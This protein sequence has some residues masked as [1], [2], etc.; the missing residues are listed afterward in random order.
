[1]EERIQKM[2]EFY[3]TGLVKSI[4]DI[5]NGMD[6][7]S[8]IEQTLPE[9]ETKK[10]ALEQIQD[11]NSVNM[12]SASTVWSHI[13]N[14]LLSAILVATVSSLAILLKVHSCPEPFNEFFPI[15]G[16]CYHIHDGIRTWE[17]AND[18]CEDKN[19]MLLEIYT[20]SEL[21]Y[22]ER[23]LNSTFLKE[24]SGMWLGAS[25][26]HTKNTFR[27]DSTRKEMTFEGSWADGFPVRTSSAH[28]CLSMLLYKEFK[29]KWVNVECE[30]K[31]RFICKMSMR[32]PTNNGSSD[33]EKSQPP[34]P[35][36]F[37][38]L[39]SWG[40]EVFESSSLGMRVMRSGYHSWNEAA[41]LCESLNMSL[42]VADT[43]F[44]LRL[45]LRKAT[46]YLSNFTYGKYLTYEKY[47]K[48]WR[49][50]RL[51][52]GAV[53]RP[54]VSSLYEFE[55]IDG[56]K[57]NLTAR[58]FYYSK[59]E[60][61]EQGKNCLYTY[62]DEYIEINPLLYLEDCEETLFF[63]AIICEKIGHR[64]LCSNDDDCHHLASCARGKCICNPGY[65]GNGFHC[66]DMNECDE[67]EFHKLKIIPHSCSMGWEDTEKEKCKNSVGSYTCDG[68][69]PYFDREKG[70]CD[71]SK[72]SR[73]NCL[74]IETEPVPMD[75][76]SKITCRCKV[77]FIN[78]GRDC[79]RIF[80]SYPRYMLSEGSRSLNWEESRKV[81]Q[82]GGGDLLSHKSP[83]E[84]SK[85]NKAFSEL[86]MIWH[87]L[88]G[89]K[90]NDSIYWVGKSLESHFVEAKDAE[91]YP[92][93]SG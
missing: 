55:W 93:L 10:R 47:E 34:I 52:L 49:F 6:S 11:R 31:L 68:C 26:R 64:Y 23:L 78:H 4:D 77:G 58:T 70:I 65:E 37:F 16:Q 92:C 24:K 17:E 90:K 73:Q 29:K 82:L 33:T 41:S 25:D 72:F 39:G 62:I 15:Q 81:C 76:A 75:G 30:E 12:T 46:W 59:K 66:S 35:T 74:G 69:D 89:R 5:D 8:G 3:I 86:S 21:D 57:D 60:L 79:L 87:W 45:V 9:Y 88:G 2:I 71:T 50:K 19:G 18:I 42:L 85:L 54:N 20:E 22:I 44:K 80:A 84:W 32:A 83:H 1:M 38:N 14:F 43:D 63:E 27:W 13:L 61:A 56:R 40:Q 48:Y 7:N 91:K 36:D 67:V 28:T 53:R 51:W